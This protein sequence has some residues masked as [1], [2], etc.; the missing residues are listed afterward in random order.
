MSNDCDARFVALLR[1]FDLKKLDRH[2]CAVY[3]IW[4]DFTLAYV[5]QA[6]HDFATKNGADKSFD[7]RWGLGCNVLEAISGPLQTFYTQEFYACLLSEEIL[8]RRYECSGPNLRRIMNMKAYPLAN[9]GG[10]LVVNSLEQ[11]QPHDELLRPS[12]SSDFSLYED[13]NL[14]IHQCGECRRVQRSAENRR[15][16]WA[17][18]WVRRPPTNAV[19]CLCP[20]CFECYYPSSGDEFSPSRLTGAMIGSQRYDAIP[21]D[22]ESPYAQ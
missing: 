20:V 7:S 11:E 6:W 16:D 18:D 8:E 10:L 5:N 12:H 14:F 13:S 17:P 4:P 19:Q 21:F 3:G 2:P 9:G 22:L 15:W 1:G